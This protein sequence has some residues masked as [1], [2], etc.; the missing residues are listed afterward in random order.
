MD[1]R[2]D[3]S[4]KD[5][6]FVG[7]VK[8]TKKTSPTVRSLALLRKE[9]YSAQVTERYNPYAHVRIDLFGFIDVVAIRADV[10]GVVGVQTTSQSNAS[11]R[12]HKI[13]GIPEAKMW[14]EAGNQIIIHGWSKK[15]KKGKRK[16]WNANTRE[17]TLKDFK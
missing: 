11:T 1:H 17:I 15:G 7:D 12:Y 9:G 8:M 3:G 14:L 13:L 2:V 6:K 5:L 16:L 10:K 4:L